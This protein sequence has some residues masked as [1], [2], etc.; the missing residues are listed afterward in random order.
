MLSFIT[1]AK[2]ALTHFTYLQDVFLRNSHVIV[3]ITNKRRC[4]HLIK[5]LICTLLFDTSI[6][7]L[8]IKVPTSSAAC[9]TMKLSDISRLR[10]IE[11]SVSYFSRSVEISLAM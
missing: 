6:D 10:S 7:V 1:G 5:F 2:F 4:R 11:I 9:F 8:T 3:R